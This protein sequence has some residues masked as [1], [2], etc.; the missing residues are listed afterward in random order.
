MAHLAERR[1]KA[2]QTVLV[3]ELAEAYILPSRAEEVYGPLVADD[4]VENVYPF[5]GPGAP[6]ISEY[7]APEIAALLGISKRR[8]TILIEGAVHLKWQLPGLFDRMERLLIDADRAVQASFAVSVLPPELAVVAAERWLL[9]QERYSWTGAF[10]KLSEFIAEVDPALAAKDAAA[11]EKRHVSIAAGK[12]HLGDAAVGYLEATLDVV[13]A[14]LFDAALN[15]IAGLLKT[16]QGDESSKEVR[17]AKA[18]GVLSRPAYALAL[19][20]QGAQEAPDPA[21]PVEPVAGDGRPLHGEAGRY[22]PAGCA[23][24]VCGTVTVGLEKL[25]PRVSV[26]V[27]V[28]ADAVGADGVARIADATVIATATLGEVLGGKTVQLRP[29]IDL[30]RVAGED[31]YRPSLATRRAVLRRWRHEAF[32]F[33]HRRSRGLDLDH[34]DPY[35][36]DGSPGQ[37]N[38]ANLLPLGR[39]NHRAKTARIWM[40]RID[41]LGRAIW[42]S[43][44]GYQYIVTP[45]GTQPVLNLRRYGRDRQ[46]AP[47]PARAA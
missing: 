26:E 4:L 36:W 8:A 25:Q 47:A 42:D 46:R 10:A 31:Q 38:S 17:R 3:A 20:Q 33:S 11:L 37:T 44:L 24:H 2:E 29:V 41:H 1:A 7:A 27:V 22:L 18:F 43:P 40:V 15:Q 9:I 19:I 13:D 6:L 21:L 35:R 39:G 23:G 12:G 16:V 14:K 30:P 45:H 5:G 32:P 28:E 34:V